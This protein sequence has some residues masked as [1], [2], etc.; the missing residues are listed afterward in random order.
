MEGDY[1][2]NDELNSVGSNVSRYALDIKEIILGRFAEVLIEHTDNKNM[3][4]KIL[5]EIKKIANWID[6]ENIKKVVELMR[7]N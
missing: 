2:L 5:N 1:L 7:E 4:V 6:I 3:V